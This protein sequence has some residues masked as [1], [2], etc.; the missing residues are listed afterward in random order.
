VARF[1]PAAVLCLAMTTT[2]AEAQFWQ[3]AH[4]ARIASG[5]SI[6]GN[7]NAWWGLAAG[8]YARG[9]VP[10][11]GA[12]MTF[13]PTRRMPLGHVAMVSRVVS[14][15]EV[16]L[17]H[18]NWSRRG[19]I[20]YDVR[21]VDVSPEGD[22]SEVKVWYGPTGDLGTSTYAIRGFIYPAAAPAPQMQMAA[23]PAAPQTMATMM[24]PAAM[25]DGQYS[26]RPRPWG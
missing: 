9:N 10:E 7:A 1:A 19:R 23:A 21:A 26:Y 4:Y 8:H 11:A 5:I 22:W 25:P 14:A 2:P 12:V 16:L 6:H 13:V 15:R 24:V 17:T 20:E 18:A 3:C